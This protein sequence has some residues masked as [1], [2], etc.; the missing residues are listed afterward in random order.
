M[1]YNLATAE[2]QQA[3]LD[4]LNAQEVGELFE[5]D[6]LGYCQAIY[7][8]RIKPDRARMAAAFKALPF[9]RPALAATATLNLSEGIGAELE[10]RRRRSEA[11]ML[12]RGEPVFS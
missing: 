9:E 6:A 8:G 2:G 7:Q 12:A 10:K 5:G 11:L 3:R 4:K 1:Q